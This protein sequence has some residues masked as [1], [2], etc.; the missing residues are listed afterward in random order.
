MLSSKTKED[1]AGE[2]PEA[3]AILDL[4]KFKQE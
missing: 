2:T 4:T 1:T 3:K